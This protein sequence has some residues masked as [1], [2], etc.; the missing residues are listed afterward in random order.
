MVD[1]VRLF[2]TDEVDFLTLAEVQ[3]RIL[4]INPAYEFTFDQG[5]GP[6]DV[7]IAR[8]PRPKVRGIVSGDRVDL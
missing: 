8:V 4:H 1:D 3:A 7:M 5:T 6:Q 2:G